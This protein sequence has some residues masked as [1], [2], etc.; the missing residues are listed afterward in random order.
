MEKASEKG[1]IDIEEYVRELIRREVAGETG[2]DIDSLMEKIKPR[3][4]RIV[5]DIVNEYMRIVF[6]NRQKIAEL[7]EK[8]DE[9][10]R[11]IEEALAKPA[12]RQ[13]QQPRITE[14]QRPRRRKR[15]IEILHEQKILF[16]SRLGRLRDRDRFFDYLKREGAIILELEGERVAVDPEFWNNFLEKISSIKTPDE[17]ETQRYLSPLE[18]EL[19]NRLR[20]SQLVIFDSKT[21]SW[22][23]MLEEY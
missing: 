19:F 13:I 16:E 14:A 9:I 20:A 15:G 1:F 12:P 6:E 7:S 21:R 10:N 18:K 22:R 4:K 11:K 5:E 3:I 2:Y 8:I 23:V 17:V